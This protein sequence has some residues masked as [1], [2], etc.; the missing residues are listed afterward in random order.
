[1]TASSESFPAPKQP[2][3]LPCF[4]L[5]Y[6]PTQSGWALLSSDG[7]V[8][9]NDSAAEILRRCDGQRSVGAIVAELE[10][11][12][13]TRGLAPQIQSLIDEGVRRGWIR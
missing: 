9:I 8:Q 6:E 13:D 11:I 10:Q 4:R 5:Q 1:M 3:L 12:F 2:L 7:S